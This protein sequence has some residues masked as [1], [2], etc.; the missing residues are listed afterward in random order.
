MQPVSFVSLALTAATGGA[1]LLY[2]N[3]LMSQ[4]LQ[5]SAHL[6]CEFVMRA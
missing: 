3:H 5:K 6:F 1:L 2:Y 4:K